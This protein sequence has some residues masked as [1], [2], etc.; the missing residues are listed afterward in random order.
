MDDLA[1]SLMDMPLADVE[2]P[3]NVE[4]PANCNVEPAGPAEVGLSV[5]L[6]SIIGP[7]AVNPAIESPD[8][9]PPHVEWLS[10]IERQDPERPDNIEG[11]N[12]EWAAVEWQ[13]IE[14]QDV[15]RPEVE[16]AD[17]GGQLEIQPQSPGLPESAD[18]IHVQE[19]R[20]TRAFCV[21]CRQ[22]KENWRP[23]NNMGGFLGHLEP[24]LLTR[25]L[26][27]RYLTAAVKRTLGV[28]DFEGQRQ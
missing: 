16:Q 5:E 3:T 17:L 14:W 21:Y 7:Q 9:E 25:L 26:I 20:S 24:M 19:R 13:D 1:K 22:H 15:E 8:I 12:V 28:I 4:P 10:D 2:P 18:G 6:Q 11:S 23:H 27:A